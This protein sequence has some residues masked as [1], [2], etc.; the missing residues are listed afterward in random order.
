MNR[1]LAVKKGS[2]KGQSADDQVVQ[3]VPIITLVGKMVVENLT[4]PPNR[5]TK[6]LAAV[7]GLDSGGKIGHYRIP[8]GGVDFLVDT[9]VG[10]N[11]DPLFQ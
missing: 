7:P 2:G 9:A 6:G 5:G 4:R 1:K 10:E 11:P 8:F 3:F